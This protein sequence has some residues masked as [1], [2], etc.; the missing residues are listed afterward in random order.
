MTDD[1]K[2]KLQDYKNGTLKEGE[3]ADLEQQLEKMEIYQ[4]YFDEML[5]GE[6][7]NLTAESGR[8]TEREAKMH[9]RE[10]RLLRKG[11]WRNRVG[12]ALTLVCLYIGVTIV[13]G[14]GTSLYYTTGDPD[15]G[16]V[17]RDVVESAFAVAYPNVTVHLSS[18]TGAYFNMNINSKMTKRVGDEYLEVGNFSG[19]FLFNWLRLYDFAWSDNEAVRSAI[20]QFP[21]SSELNSDQEWNRLDKLPERTVTEAYVSYNRLYTTDEFL[22]QFTGK[23]LEPVW[24]A[25]D[26]GDHAEGHDPGGV[27]GD[28]IGFPSMPVW[29]PDDGEILNRETPRKGLFSSSGTSTTRYPAIEQ[30]GSGQLR[31]DNF[32]K[33]L[34]ILDQHK[35]LADRLIHAVDITQSLAYVEKHGVNIYGAVVTGPT[36]EVLKLKNDPAVSSIRVGK[37]TLWNW[38]HES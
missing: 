12:T 13:S 17:N 26:N 31:N 7:D 18:N 15:L 33:T 6:E 1:F 21:G 37:V 28:P 22:Q 5:E 8:M 38:N 29:H 2:R 24:F 27:I 3:Q 10:A 23:Q 36:K 19:S 11:K 9:K 4:A 20:F 25:V 16:D 35:S 14:I 30:Y 32:I 34:R